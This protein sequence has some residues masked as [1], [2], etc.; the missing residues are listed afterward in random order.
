ML[1]NEFKTTISVNLP[2]KEVNLIDEQRAKLKKSRS[3]FIADIVTDAIH[4][5]KK[6]TNDISD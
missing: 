1:Y 3:S 6:N 4:Q 5:N 2:I